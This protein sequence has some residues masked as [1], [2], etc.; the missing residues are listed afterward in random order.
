LPVLSI[1]GAIIECVK[2]TT[3]AQV[4]IIIGCLL[5]LLV[6]QGL[7]LIRAACN[8]SVTCIGSSSSNMLRIAPCK[9]ICAPAHMT[10]ATAGAAAAAAD[11]AMYS[12]YSAYTMRPAE[13]PY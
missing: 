4:V 1:L 10:D 7:L 5:L 12:C 6:Q 8:F 3:E 9:S 13:M 11:V 2:H